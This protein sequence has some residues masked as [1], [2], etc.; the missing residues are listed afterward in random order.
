MALPSD[1]FAPRDTVPAGVVK[2]EAAADW[3]GTLLRAFGGNVEGWEWTGETID[4]KKPEGR[5]ACG[6]EGCRYLYPWEHKG[7]PGQQVITGSTCVENVPGIS[8][9]SLA[10]IRAGVEAQR[11]AAAEAKRKASE[12]VK[13]DAIA[14]CRERVAAVWRTNCERLLSGALPWS[15]QRRLDPSG[16]RAYRCRRQLSDIRHAA[17]LKSPAGQLN[18]LETVGHWIGGATCLSGEEAAAAQACERTIAEARERICSPGLSRADFGSPEREQW[19][20]CQESSRLVEAADRTG[21]Y[22]SKMKYLEQAAGKVG[23]KCKR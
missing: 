20:R 2:G 10:A 5:C 18:A 3:M 11:K 4:L 6:H 7:R 8:E 19:N 1:L 9:S 14:A 22:G 16:E 13:Q 12:V 21:Q 17:T 15:E 23:A